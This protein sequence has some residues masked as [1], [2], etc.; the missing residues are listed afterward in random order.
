MREEAFRA[1]AAARLKPKAV[2]SYLSN[3]RHVEAIVGSDLDANALTEPAVQGIL[4]QVAAAGTPDK[5]VSDCGSALRMY[6]VFKAGASS[7]VSPPPLSGQESAAESPL[8]PTTPVV[9]LSRMRARDLLVLHASVIDEF[10]GRGIARTGNGPLG[11][12]AET[13]FARALGWRLEANSAAGHDAT[14]A[15]GTRYQ[16]KSRRITAANPSRQ[17]GAIRKLPEMPFDMLAAI[18]FDGRFDVLRAVVIPVALVLKAAKPVTHTNS[19]R[20]MLNDRLMA[21]D[22]VRDVSE[23]IR[24]AHRVI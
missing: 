5:R 4:R 15:A 21:E 17:L 14:D 22:G 9:D 8:E 16:I 10:R 12:Y 13:L 6:A 2:S 11:D 18:L 3:C 7:S 20:L 19:W 1:F 23:T 24:L